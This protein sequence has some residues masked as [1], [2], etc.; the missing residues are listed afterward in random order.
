[1]RRQRVL[2]LAGWTFWRCCAS[3]WCQRKEEVFEELVERLTVMGIEPIS[4]V[5]ALPHL[6]ESRTWIP[7][8][9]LI[10]HRAIRIAAAIECKHRQVGGPQWQFRRS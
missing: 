8:A 9:D 5:A 4:A 7:P 6:V 3:T 10:R 1:M 2:E